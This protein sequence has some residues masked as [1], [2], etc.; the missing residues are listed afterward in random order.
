MKRVVLLKKNLNANGG[1]EKYTRKLAE[2]FAKKGCHVTLLAAEDGSI[3]YAEW[4]KLR[5][6]GRGFLRMKSFDKACK[7]WVDEHSPD[8]VFGLDRH[9]FQTHYRAGNGVHRHYLE[10]RKQSCSWLK[11][12]SFPL[13]PLHHL[14]LDMEKKTYE[15]PNIKTIFVNSKM[16]KD[17]IVHYY[18]KADSDK[19][20]VVHN[21]VEWNDLESS[22][23]LWEEVKENAPF[24]FL[25]VGNGYERKGLSSLLQALAK[26][27]EPFSLCVIGKDRNQKKYEVLAEQLG[28]HRQITFYGPQDSIIPFYMIADATIIPSTYDPFANVTLESLAMGVPVA[29][30]IHNGAKEVISE[31]N[32]IVIPDIKDSDSFAEVLMGMMQSPKTPERARRIRESVKNYDYSRQLHLIIDKTLETLA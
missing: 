18:S 19:I 11:R 25:F 6:W 14:I 28:I 5:C 30:S 4:I 32:G 17:E 24:L 15:D 10:I 20:Q 22:F 9:S 29:T 1:L 13:N 2:E 8:C 7:E 16:V 12:L 27:K 31:E 23:N 26:V 3:P 21:G